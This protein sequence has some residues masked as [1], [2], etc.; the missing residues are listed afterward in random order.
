MPLMGTT[1]GARIPHVA[2]AT[3]SDP[4]TGSVAANYAVWRGANTP[5]SLNAG[6]MTLAQQTSAVANTIVRSVGALAMSGF[7]CDFRIGTI[8]SDDSGQLWISNVAVSTDPGMD[9]AS[10]VP[11]R[12]STADATQRPYLYWTGT[13][14]SA[15]GSTALSTGVWYRF[16]CYLVATG[17]VYWQIDNLDVPAMWGNGTVV[18]AS[19]VARSMGYLGYSTDAP[20]T[21]G[22]AE[23]RRAQITDCPSLTNHG[24]P[25]DPVNTGSSIALSLS[26]RQAGAVAPAV[27]LSRGITPRNASGDWAFSVVPDGTADGR[28]MVGIVRAGANLNQYPG[29]DTN[30]YGYWGN[31]GD[32]YINNANSAYGATWSVGDEVVGRLNAGAL[33]MYKNGVSQGVLVSGLTGD[34]YPA[35]GFGTGVAGTRY[36]LLNVGTWPFRGITLTAWG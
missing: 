33:T 19:A 28:L 9:A 5:F 30:G 6:V 34:W 25:L 17:Y 26:N 11:A 23:Y 35:I 31:S 27:G 8:Q 4:L 10:F 12:D 7:T 1:A 22:Q 3:F 16:N 14:F 18:I 2:C 15:L 24:N 13:G 36:G 32:K 20:N 21:T 29:F